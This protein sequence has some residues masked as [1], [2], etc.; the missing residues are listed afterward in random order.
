M[1]EEIEGFVSG[2]VKGIVD[3]PDDVHV[4]VH[5]TSARYIVEL[6]TAQTDTGNVI[7]RGGGNINALRTLVDSFAGCHDITLS[8]DYL[9]EVKRG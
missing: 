8:F 5:R 3:S 6:S 2:I 1:V 7:G 4:D 9:T